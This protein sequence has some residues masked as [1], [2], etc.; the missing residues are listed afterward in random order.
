MENNDFISSEFEWSHKIITGFPP[1]YEISKIQQYLIYAN[2][3]NNHLPIAGVIELQCQSLNLLAYDLLCKLMP[4][5]LAD[6]CMDLDFFVY[7]L[8]PIAGL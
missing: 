7:P 1:K 5:N 8:D 4:L 3:W 6:A 2:F